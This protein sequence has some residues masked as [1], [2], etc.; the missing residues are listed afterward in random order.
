M[1]GGEEWRHNCGSCENRSDCRWCAVYGYLETGRFS[2]PVP[3]L[4]RVAEETRRH[5]Q[6][7][8]SRHRRYF[9]IAGITIRLE[10]DLPMDQLRFAEA[11]Q[12]FEVQ[13]PGNDMVTLRHVFELPDLQGKILACRFTARRRGPSTVKV[14]ASFTWEFLRIRSLLN[15]IVWPYLIQTLLMG[16]STALPGKKPGFAVEGFPSLTLF[17]TDQIL[18]AQLLAQ[19]GMAVTCMLPA[20]S[21]K[22]KGCYLSV[23]PGRVSPQPRSCSEVRPK[24]SVM[25]NHRPPLGRRV[26]DSRHLEPRRR[27]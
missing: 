22:T 27:S 6:E 10:S 8:P 12:P 9:E 26:Q 13:G 2:A 3:Y 4:C 21:W 24:S 7:W 5:K 11:L 1:R 23:I 25:T 16:L 20:R 14:T 19:R 18:V 17:P 15:R